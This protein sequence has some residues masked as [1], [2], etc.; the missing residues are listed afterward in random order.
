[1]AD[2]F[3][4]RPV[5]LLCPVDHHGRDHLGHGGDEAVHHCR[6]QPPPLHHHCGRGA[7][8]LLSHG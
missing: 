1:M 4:E 5:Q 2:P 8:G 7:G 6:L 3:L